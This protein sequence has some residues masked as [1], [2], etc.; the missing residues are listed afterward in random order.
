MQQILTT[1][2]IINIDPLFSSP[3]QQVCVR[4]NFRIALQIMCHNWSHKSADLDL[5]CE[6]QWS[7]IGSG[8][9]RLKNLE[10]YL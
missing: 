6:I 10:R 3:L 2:D 7:V 8:S 1:S 5:D 4:N 9:V